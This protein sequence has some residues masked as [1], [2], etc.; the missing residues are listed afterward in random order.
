M[1]FTA[2]KHH[3]PSLTTVAEVA[4]DLAA[5]A[6]TPSVVNGNGAKQASCGHPS[7]VVC[8]AAMNGTLF[9]EPRPVLPPGN[10]PPR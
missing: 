5:K 8:T 9:S 4:N 7:G 3:S 10:S 6:A 1:S 2:P